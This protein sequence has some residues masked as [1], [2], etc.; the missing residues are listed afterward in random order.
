MKIDPQLSVVLGCPGPLARLRWTVGALAA[1]TVADQIELVLVTSQ[2][3]GLDELG[4]AVAAF[5]RVEVVYRSPVGSAAAINAAG[6]R[7]ARAPIVAFGEE[8]AFPEPAW[9]EALLDRHAEGWAAV[10]PAVRNANPAT[11]VSWCDFLTGYGPWMAPAC[12]GERAM[13]PGH[14]TSYRRDGLLALGDRL[15]EGLAVEA[16]IQGAL[17]AGAAGRLCVEPRAITH[18]VNFALRRSYLRAAYLNGRGFAAARCRGWSAP[19][20]LAYCVASGLIPAV[21]LA[22]VVR[23]LDAPHRAEIP[24]A[25]VLPALAVGLAVDAA[26]QAIGCLRGA[27]E[28]S[29]TAIAELEFE[30]WRHVPPSDRRSLAARYGP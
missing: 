14:N 11:V 30:R 12:G 28:A 16:V 26:G 6:V 17:P 21:R 27:D 19:R 24:L 7:A 23:M 15:E 10:A 1:Q 18:H 5:A 22:R 29:E 8:H 13:L 4:E 25:R 3:A 20:R 2:P 9:A